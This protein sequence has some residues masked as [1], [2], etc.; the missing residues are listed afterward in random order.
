MIG[1]T[2]P[3]IARLQTFVTHASLQRT[4]GHLVLVSLSVFAQFALSNSGRMGCTDDIAET[5]FA[6]AQQSPLGWSN[7]IDIRPFQETCRGWGH[8]LADLVEAIPATGWETST[9]EEG[10]GHK[11]VT[12]PR[13]Y[14]FHCDF[15]RVE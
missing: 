11:H 5:Y 6:L 7:E 14:K 2:L 3:E 12:C 8:A 15:A 1:C 9:L 13:H 4:S 10:Q